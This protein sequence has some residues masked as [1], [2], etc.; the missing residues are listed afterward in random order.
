MIFP[1]PDW[2]I[3]IGWTRRHW[4]CRDSANIRWTH[5]NWE[6]TFLFLH[7][8]NK[9]SLFLSQITFKPAQKI[10]FTFKSTCEHK[11]LA[12]FLFYMILSTHITQPYT[13]NIWS[14][15]LTLKLHTVDL[16]AVPGYWH[17]IWNL[18]D[19]SGFGPRGQ[20][21]NTNTYAN[22]KHHQK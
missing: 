10:L 8:Q 13:V 6:C 5:G 20:G 16:R 9:K 21:T 17:F 11:L 19:R 4:N 1:Q 18:W 15:S 2:Q 7:N 22:R 14:T 3:R 12:T